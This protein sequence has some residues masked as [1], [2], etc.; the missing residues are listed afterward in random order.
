MVPQL[1]PYSNDEATPGQRCPSRTWLKRW[2]IK[3][4]HVIHILCIQDYPA[5]TDTSDAWK[6]APSRQIVMVQWFWLT[7][8][9]KLFG[10]RPF[11]FLIGF[12]LPRNSNVTELAPLQFPASPPSG[13]EHD[14]DRKACSW[15][16][17][18][19]L[20]QVCG[21]LVVSMTYE[22]VT[23][24]TNML[25]VTMSPCMVS[26]WFTLINRELETVI[27]KPVPKRHLCA[28]PGAQITQPLNHQMHVTCT[29]CDKRIFSE[30]A[31]PLSTWWWWKFQIAKLGSLSN[32]TSINRWAFRASERPKEAAWMPRAPPPPGSLCHPSI[33]HRFWV[34]LFAMFVARQLL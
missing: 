18:M 7:Y 21:F 1:E 30:T 33:S 28:T 9:Q 27:L 32:V 4:P 22:N 14:M 25:Y 2:E 10:K 8:V 12:W 11:L 16:G 17:Q 34:H 15:A 24:C 20:L 5:I 3:T 13:L 23:L 6:D 29:V 26:H 19:V 31:W